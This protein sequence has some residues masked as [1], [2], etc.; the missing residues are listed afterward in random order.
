[1]RNNH[2]GFNDRHPPSV[3]SES[4]ALAKKSNALNTSVWRQAFQ[5]NQPVLEWG[6][7][8]KWEAIDPMEWAIRECETPNLL[9]LLDGCREEAWKLLPH[10]IKY[11]DHDAIVW[12][13]NHVSPEEWRT[14][15]DTAPKAFPRLTAWGQAMTQA[16]PA[17]A[18]TVQK[19]FD[20]LWK[21]FTQDPALAS[22]AFI[23]TELMVQLLQADQ[24]IF[25]KALLHAA[26]EFEIQSVME[27]AFNNQ[28]AWF[29]DE[30]STVLSKKMPH[31]W[32]KWTRN[33]GQRWLPGAMESL[34][35]EGVTHYRT[36]LTWNKNNMMRYKAFWKRVIP[37]IK[38]QNMTW[39]ASKSAA[40]YFNLRHNLVG[41]GYGAVKRAAGPKS[42]EGWF[43]DVF[44][45]DLL[46][47]IKL[48]RKEKD[49]MSFWGKAGLTLDDSPLGQR[50]RATL[51]RE[52]L[53]SKHWVVLMKSKKNETPLMAL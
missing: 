27:S 6:A 28:C 43:D 45:H 11:H 25:A 12:A 4:F 48:P 47:L 46:T 9:S 51:E 32:G 42:H 21:H 38:E 53:C 18:P 13:L 50:T 22:L 30:A 2:P 10:A 5:K 35:E 34:F 14:W 23:H 17:E 33:V 39:D 24:L 37:W 8:D 41:W 1:M 7:S 29:F 15:S 31:R 16:L 49:V 52:L 3:W 44:Q 26:E 36:Q 19:T 40:Q 20:L